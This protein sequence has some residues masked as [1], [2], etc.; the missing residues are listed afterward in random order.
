MPTGICVSVGAHSQDYQANPVTM[1]LALVWPLKCGDPFCFGHPKNGGRSSRSP[2]V[3]F[4]PNDG[5]FPASR[6]VLWQKKRIA[7]NREK[8]WVPSP[9]KSQ[10][11]AFASLSS[12]FSWAAIGVD[13]CKERNQLLFRDSR[14]V[15]ELDIA[16]GIS[17]FIVSGL[18]FLGSL[19]MC[20]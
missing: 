7:K 4:Y 1:C 20:T 9:F 17:S 12:L 2:L 3:K 16:L 19:E 14:R 11:L 18:C 13:R 15:S 8:R 10:K 5:P 6:R